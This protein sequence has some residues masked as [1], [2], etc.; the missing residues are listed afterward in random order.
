MYITEQHIIKKT[1]KQWKDLDYLCFLSKNIYNQTLY[2][3]RQHYF[4]TKEYLTYPEVNKLFIKQE[5]ESYRKLP[6][7]VSRGS[8]QLVDREF[9]SFFALLK[10]KQKGEY[11]KSVS[12]PRYADK[13]KG[14]KPVIYQKQALSFIRKDYIKLS[15]TKIYIKTNKTKEEVK[16]VRIV[17]RNG[18]VII[19]IVC[20]VD[21]PIEKQDN[22]RYASIDLGLNNLA[23]ITSNVF[24]PY[25]IN[26]KPLKS[27]NQYYNKL[28]ATETSTL[29]K[30]LGRKTSNKIYKIH[31]KAKNKKDDYL[32][33]AS[34]YIVNHLVTNNINT[35]IIG[36]NQGWKQ[37][38]NIGKV[39][40][41]N[42]VQISYAR[43]IN[44]L[45]YKCRREGIQV[46]LNE[47]SYTSKSSFMDN[48]EIKKHETYLGKRIKRGLFRT[49][50]GTFINADVNA[51]YNIMKKTLQ[52]KE[53]WNLKLFR[54]CIEV[55]ST[56]NIITI[57]FN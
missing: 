49:S 2:Q 12:I 27:I 43:L 33:K 52:A 20:K 55:C 29:E 42:F 53:V 39:N 54:D 17:P 19:E 24:N 16:E 40:N 45:E 46:I 32:H 48:E 56:P 15:K 34:A 51:S 13:I 10:L 38:I 47:E 3:V 31:L 7:K 14:R 9:K 1:N 36:Y 22:Q 6:A 18:Y 26:G 37:D 25:I 57:G 5:L 4:R 21:E 44:M 23:T 28:I 35:L 30:N 8:Q 50:N 41:Q 11:D